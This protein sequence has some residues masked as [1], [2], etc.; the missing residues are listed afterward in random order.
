MAAPLI[1]VSHSHQNDTYSRDFVAALSSGQ[2][3]FEIE[4]ALALFR[5]GSI[6]TIQ[7]VTAVSCKV[8]HSLGSFPRH[9]QPDGTPLARGSCLRSLE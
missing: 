3:N 9:E 1:F 7:C 4:S 2:V 6:R 5:T 8:P